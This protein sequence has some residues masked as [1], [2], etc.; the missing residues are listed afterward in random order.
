MGLTLARALR[1]LPHPPHRAPGVAFVGAGGKSTAMFQLA[2]ELPPPVIATATTHLGVWQ[3]SSA[4]EHIIAGKPD[5]LAGREF[6]GV[7]LLTGLIREDDRTEG[8][9]QDVLSWLHAEA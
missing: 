4:D 1:L 8:V 6:R 7:T 2:R 9:S 3:A 5:S